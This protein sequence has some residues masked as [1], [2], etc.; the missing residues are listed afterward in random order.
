MALV[1][2]LVSTLSFA[3]T[4]VV[5]HIVAEGETLESIAQRYNTS[6]E[7]IIAINPDA[8]QAIYVGMEMKI[9]VTIVENKNE[10]VAAQPEVA[11]VSEPV[12]N[13]VNS[14]STEEFKRWTMPG[15]YG[16]LAS[17]KSG[18]NPWKYGFDISLGANYYFIK[19]A[20][21]GA[22]L[23]YTLLAWKD[24]MAHFIGIPIEVGGKF[25]MNEKHSVMPYLGFDFQICVKEKYDGDS[26]YKEMMKEVAKEAQGNIGVGFRIGVRFV[27]KKGNG[28]G[29][30]YVLPL[31]DNQ[32]GLGKNG[33]PEISFVSDF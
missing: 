12:A 3:Q 21:V 23:G 11:V 15:Q 32:K 7:T 9:P 33:Y 29:I 25:K 20:Y 28:L 6:V 18:D 31:N 26:K 19:Q 5:N 10:T 13:N 2:V 14:V 30:A 27:G 8:A 17:P 24:W 22:R 16:L 1:F 4:R